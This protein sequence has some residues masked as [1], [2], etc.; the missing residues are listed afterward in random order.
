MQGDRSD[1][2]CRNPL[3]GEWLQTLAERPGEFSGM[4]AAAEAGRAE[5]YTDTVR[6]I[7][8]QPATWRATAEHLTGFRTMMADCLARTHRMV[9]TG[10][11]SSQYAGE[12]VAPLLEKE[13]RRPV[14]V[15]GGGDLLLSRAASV[16]GEPTLVVSLAR[17][18]D[19][20]ESVAVVETLLECE[21]ET[22]HL[23]ITC[24]PDGRLA[25]EFA[26]TPRVAVVPLCDEVNDR[27]LVMTSSFTNMVLAAKFLGYLNRAEEFQAAVERLSHAGRE[28][29]L[30][31]PDRLHEVV[32]G[33]IRRIVFLAGGSRHGGAREAALKLLEMTAGRVATMPQTYLGLRHG[34]MCFLD[35][36]T[37]V[38]CFLSADPVIRHYESDLIVELEGKRPGARKLL[39]GV[40]EFGREL[41]GAGDLPI[42]YQIWNRAS[43]DELAVLDAM[44]GQIL[45]FQRCRM[46]GLSP[47]S[48]SVDG[49][50]S[51]VVGKF[52][53][54]RAQE[55]GR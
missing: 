11:G 32:S 35:D 30:N 12:C 4:L 2:V 33:D 37:L 13:L 15:A 52:R 55:N 1:L 23:V 25:R 47:D 14:V 3:V 50:I 29:L 48:P 42:P 16:S 41:R 44:I 38:V 45:G 18:G 10:S 39:A 34:P 53:I 8:Q 7:S 21:P 27:S 24:N 36:Q 26:H 43:E 17:S 19:S 6:E 51:R 54:H 40:G 28:L 49:V 9:L 22:R 31:W 46:E 5:G 20:P